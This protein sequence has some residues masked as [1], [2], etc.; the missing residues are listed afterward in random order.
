MSLSC[1]GRHCGICVN[2]KLQLRQH[3]LYLSFKNGCKLEQKHFIKKLGLLMA[4][5]KNE[6]KRDV[7]LHKT[8]NSLKSDKYMQYIA[9]IYLSDF[10]LF[11]F[12]VRE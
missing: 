12:F 7:E 9:V 11:Y 1:I 8:N 6:N 5:K 10:R 3:Y 2:A 4:L